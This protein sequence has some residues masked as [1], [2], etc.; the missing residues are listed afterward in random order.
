MIRLFNHTQ[1]KDRP[2]RRAL[3]FAAR[4]IGVKG[5]VCVKVTR[6]LKPRPAG[7]ANRLFPY[8]GYMRGTSDRKGRNGRLLGNSPGFITVSLPNQLK[9][10][11]ATDWLD[12]AKWFMHVAMH[13]MAHVRQFR[14]NRYSWLRQ[15]EAFRKAGRRMKH[16][17]RP[18]EVDAE[19]QIYDVCRNRRKDARRQDEVIELATA[20][21]DNERLRAVMQG[22]LKGAQT[23]QQFPSHQNVKTEET[24]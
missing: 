14:E 12:V 3:S 10:P 2:L 24:Q 18:C 20:L 6:S 16:N 17:S 13:E 19:N 23:L 7:H 15:Q 1:H 5:D 21:E 9:R 22:C 8:V 11:K 4:T